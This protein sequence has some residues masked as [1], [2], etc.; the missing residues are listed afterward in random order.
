VFDV[1]PDGQRFLINRLAERAAAPA[2]RVVTNW[3]A[4][5][6]PAD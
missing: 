5:L 1:A 3:P 6:S 4:T 2:T